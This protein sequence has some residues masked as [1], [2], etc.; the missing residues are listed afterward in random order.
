M[1]LPP[2]SVSVPT[3]DSGTSKLQLPTGNESL[4]EDYGEPAQNTRTMGG[5]VDFFSSLGTER[6]KKQ[7]EEKPDPDKVIISHSFD[8]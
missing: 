1:L 7:R 8:G 3:S 4:T 2:S 6:K 5:G